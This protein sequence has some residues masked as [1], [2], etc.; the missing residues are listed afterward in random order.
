MNYLSLDLYCEEGFCFVDRLP[1]AWQGN[2]CSKANQQAQPHLI[3][4]LP[5]PSPGNG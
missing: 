3:G 2:S 5:G 1:W 4:S